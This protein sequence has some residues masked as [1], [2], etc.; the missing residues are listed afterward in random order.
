MIKKHNQSHNSVVHGDHGKCR[1]CN[2]HCGKMWWYFQFPDVRMLSVSHPALSM[3]NSQW[4]QFSMI[5]ECDLS[6]M[7]I[8]YDIWFNSIKFYAIAIRNN[9]QTACPACSGHQTLPWDSIS[10]SVHWKPQTHLIGFVCLPPPATACNWF[11]F[12]CSLFFNVRSHRP[13]HFIHGQ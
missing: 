13:F 9:L 12:V 11:P 8:S 7:H 1:F 10:N 3:P 4:F 6:S 2:I 5:L